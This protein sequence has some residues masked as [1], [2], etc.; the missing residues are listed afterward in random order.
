MSK[1]VA[2]T[3]SA[4]PRPTIA[5]VQA[6]IAGW[7]DLN[8]AR[9]R[10]LASALR[11]LPQLEGRAAA[12]VR[13]DPVHSL[14]LIER[15]SPEALR[16]T[17]STFANKAACVRHVLRRLGLLAPTRVRTPKVADPGWDGLLAT[18]PEGPDFGR[19]RA[20]I[21]YCIIEAIAPEAV[22]NPTLE[23]Y[24]ERRAAERGGAKARDHARRV[25]VQWNLAAKQVPGWP[26]TRLGLRA[27]PLQY[28][29]PFDA[30]PPS[31]QQEVQQ[32]LGDIGAPADE[33]L[34]AGED[35]AKPVTPS[36][37]NTRKY[38]LRRL[39]WG[40]VQTGT[41]VESLISLRQVVTPAF[42]KPALSW[43]YKR[44]G[45]VNA[46]LGQMASTIAS[47]ANYLKVPTEAWAA[48]KP[49]LA[50]ATPAPRTE[51]TE[52]TA[53]LLDQLGQPE[54][55][56]ALLHLPSH[57]M[58]EARR[59]RAGGE[60]R[61][62]RHRA[63]QPGAAAWMAAT[64]VSV[65]ILLHAPMRL[66]NLQQLRIGQEL[67]LAQVNRT[68][69]RGTIFVAGVRVK[70]QRRLEVPLGP[71]SI[72]LLR[73]YLD[74]HRPALPCPEGVW[75]FPGQ[76]DPQQP[77]HKGAFGQAITEAIAQYLGVRVNPHAF[78]ALAGALILEA[79]PHAIDDVR[80]ILG[81]ACFETAMIYY[82]RHSQREAAKRLSAT[83]TSQRR[84]TKQQATAHFMAPE[85]RRRV[86][87]A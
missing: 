35:R 55:R 63:P 68:A 73:E 3:S 9:R 61:H 49:L 46:D 18:L 87:R 77:R 32:Y 42:I 19:L 21:S 45:E 16:I 67:Q 81:H 66:V 60:D 44:A 34:F 75:L 27:Q 43:H 58:G 50:K 78:R 7:T 6:M 56:A 86:R 70:N 51:I 82:R 47:I 2:T 31:L 80:A 74:L 69:W 23:A 5:D 20:F 8:E 85:L 59:M 33:D 17:P 62:G 28:S 36:T 71:E 53:K 12:V 54:M 64:A 57:L 13:L 48:I 26:A 11:L 29:L 79:N 4:T 84:A 83:L 52:R 41:A 37:V 72:A 38:C 10:D 24:A 22:D 25:G 30:Y 40:A 1:T 39:L 14:R 15:A 65:E 76:R